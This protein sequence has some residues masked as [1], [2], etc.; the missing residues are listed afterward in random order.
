[1]W[2][3][4][5]RIIKNGWKGFSRNVSL[6]FA[7][8]FI[9]VVVISIP[10]AL[11]LLNPISKALISDIEKKVDISVYFKEDA[12]DD[13]I[14]LVKSAISKIPEVK[15]VEYISRDQT[16]ENFIQRHKNDSVLMESLDEVGANP[17]LASLDIR[18][19]Q[20][21]QY[22][23]VAKFLENS[24]F[25]NLIYKVDYNQRKKVIDKIFSTISSINRIGLLFSLV[26]G[27]IAVLLAFNAVRVS[28]DNSREEIAIMRLVGASNWFIRG[29]FLFQGFVIGLISAVIALFLTFVF[30]LAF[31]SSFKLLTPEASIFSIFKAN[32]AILVLIQLATGIGLGMISSFIAVRKYLS[33]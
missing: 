9:M 8:I 21:S 24:P 6:N 11:F 10:T 29:P 25:K 4:L 1:M 28:I 33:I 2:T 27:I 3:S 26:L 19:W 20:A 12:T 17:F 7:T 15:E 22:E 31:N 14:S 18:A 16:L 5:K 23:Q 32:F 30:C 13:D